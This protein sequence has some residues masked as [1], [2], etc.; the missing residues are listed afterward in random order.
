[1]P[2]SKDPNRLSPDELARRVAQILAEQSPNP[3]PSSIWNSVWTWR[4]LGGLVV[5]SLM[6]G[7]AAG[8]SYGIRWWE[9]RAPAATF[10][11]VSTET[12]QPSTTTTLA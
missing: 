10:P 1:M 9:G 6:G 2:R 5:L 7:L 3:G 8:I 12:T 11:V 4:L